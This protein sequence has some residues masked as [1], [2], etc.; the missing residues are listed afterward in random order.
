LEEALYDPVA[1][2]L[3]SQHGDVG[4]RGFGA[5]VEAATWPCRGVPSQYLRRAGLSLTQAEYVAP[6]GVKQ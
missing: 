5:S 4:S 6:S 1:L 3:L 2:G